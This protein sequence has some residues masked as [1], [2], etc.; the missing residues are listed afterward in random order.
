MAS[1]KKLW[2][3]YSSDEEYTNPP[4]EPPREKTVDTKPQHNKPAEPR[5]TV[6][7]EPPAKPRQR[8]VQ[9][10]TKPKKEGQCP[11]C[12][13]ATHSNPE[14]FLEEFKA[15]CCVWCPKSKGRRH[16]ERCEGIEF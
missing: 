12:A 9:K 8:R 2:T 11:Y 13:F 4:A 6:V 5:R 15:C 3:D 7:P 10:N 14:D 16:G 1:E